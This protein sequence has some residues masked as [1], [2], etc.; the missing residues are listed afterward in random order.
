MLCVTVTNA[1]DFAIL[2]G[3]VTDVS[4]HSYYMSEMLLQH[5]LWFRRGVM[6]LEKS[7]IRLCS[8]LY[9]AALP[10]LSCLIAVSNVTTVRI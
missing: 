8:A 3:Y 10:S 9:F 4:S 1:F 6:S 5:N 7:K 2:T